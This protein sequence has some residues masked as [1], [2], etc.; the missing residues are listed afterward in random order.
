[1]LEGKGAFDTSQAVAR[2]TLRE[3]ARRSV[4]DTGLLDHL[5]RHMPRAGEVAQTS[6]VERAVETGAA[7]V[8]QARQMVVRT[9]PTSRLVQESQTRR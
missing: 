6:Y 1:V 9:L 8:V 5:L 2:G 7:D 4:G 3:E